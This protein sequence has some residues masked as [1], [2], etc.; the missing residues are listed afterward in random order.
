MRPPAL[1]RGP[2]PDTLNPTPTRRGRMT[3]APARITAKRRLGD[4]LFST[5]A[6]AAG[7]LSLGVLAGGAVF[8]TARSLPPCAVDRA[9]GKGS[10]GRF[11]ACALPLPSAP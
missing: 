11:R 7:A 9:A 4:A 10:R 3:A 8:L 2:H 5:G 1:R 6:R